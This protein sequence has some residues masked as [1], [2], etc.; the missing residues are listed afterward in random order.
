[1]ASQKVPVFFNEKTGKF[2]K[3]YVDLNNKKEVVNAYK[4]YE[5]FVGLAKKGKL[6]GQLTEAKRQ[7][8]GKLSPDLLSAYYK[9]E[10]EYLP[11]LFDRLTSLSDEP[12]ARRPYADVGRRLLMARYMDTPPIEDLPQP[13]FIPTELLPDAE[14]EYKFGNGLKLKRMLKYNI[15]SRRHVK[16]GGAASQQKDLIVKTG[17]PPK[18]LPQFVRRPQNPIEVILERLDIFERLIRNNQMS[19]EKV[20]EFI[21]IINLVYPRMNNPAHFEIITR[22]IEICELLNER[23]L[24]LSP[25]DQDVGPIFAPFIDDPRILTVDTFIHQYVNP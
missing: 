25:D 2:I 9:I 10:N 15:H 16:Q 18:E 3:D 11:I 19:L 20:D 6:L 12:I 1:M 13:D 17:V 23:G 21:T 14:A 24:L 4:R 5:P 8:T 7:Q 22:L